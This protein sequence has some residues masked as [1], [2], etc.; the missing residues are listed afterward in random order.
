VTA[1]RSDAACEERA[2]AV[3]GVRDRPPEAEAEGM[4]LRSR[5]RRRRVAEEAS[6]PVPGSSHLP[7]I[8]CSPRNRQRWTS[9]DYFFFRE[10][11]GGARG[12]ASRRGAPAHGAAGRAPSQSQ[13]QAA[14]I[15]HR[16]QQEMR[17][18]TRRR[19]SR[20]DAR[21]PRLPV[22]VRRW[23]RGPHDSVMARTISCSLRVSVG[24]VLEFG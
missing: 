20:L 8:L 24:S 10:G 3:S 19:S 14:A 4:P 1:K 23:G 12:G 11:G 13:P 17:S 18:L 5:H 15:P 2:R 9:P 22:V 6:V 7:G 16:G 21:P